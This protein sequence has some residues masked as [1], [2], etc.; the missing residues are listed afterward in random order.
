MKA[1][2]SKGRNLLD[3]GWLLAIVGLVDGGTHVYAAARCLD[4]IGQFGGFCEYALYGDL[5]CYFLVV[6]ISFL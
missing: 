6:V 1:Q 2:C 3:Y 4:H 5:Y